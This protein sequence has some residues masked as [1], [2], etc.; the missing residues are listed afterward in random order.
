MSVSDGCSIL[1]DVCGNSVLYSSFSPPKLKKAMAE[2]WEMLESFGEL[3]Y[4]C[5]VYMKRAQSSKG[6]HNHGHI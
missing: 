5:D 2:A 4:D 3:Q 6:F 1:P